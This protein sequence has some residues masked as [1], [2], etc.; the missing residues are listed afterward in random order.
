[1]TQKLKVSSL[2]NNMLK[3]DQP[4]TPYAT[5]VGAPA[6]GITKVSEGGQID[7]TPLK[8]DIKPAPLY[9][10]KS[11]GYGNLFGGTSWGT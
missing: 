11:S 6:P 10:Q 3:L 4:A 7:N 2:L 8:K 9:T 1:M 5:A